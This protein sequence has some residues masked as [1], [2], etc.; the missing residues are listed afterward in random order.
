MNRTRFL[1]LL[2]LLLATVLLA[3]PARAWPVCTRLVLEVTQ[4]P[5]PTMKVCH[6]C[7]DDVVGGSAMPEPTSTVAPDKLT[8]VVRAIMF[9]MDGCPHCHEVLDNG[10]PSIQEKYG[11]KLEIKLIELVGG[12]EVTALYQLAE[13]RGISKEKVEVPFLVIGEYTLIGAEQIPA[14]LP[15]LIEEYLTSGGV[16]WPEISGLESADKDAT[17]SPTISQ[18]MGSP[19][20]NGRSSEGIVHAVLFNTPGCHDCELI[21]RQAIAPVREKFGDKF[22][23]QTIDIVSLED[24]DYLYQAA[25][26]Y[27]LQ[28]EQVDLPLLIIGDSVLVGEK[29]ISDLPELIEGYLSAGGV[30]YPQ[31]LEHTGMQTPEVKPS[32]TANPSPMQNVASTEP[33]GFAQSTTNTPNGFLPAI[34]VMLMMVVVLAYAVL[35]FMRTVLGHSLSNPPGVGRLEWLIPILAL[36]GIGVSGYL[37]YVETQAV[38]AVCG[39]VGDCNAVQSSPY[40]RLLG[41]L[42]VGV[43]GLIG[44]I[45]ILV[46]WYIQRSPLG[47]S[48]TW[49]GF[50]L[51]II[52]FGGTLFSLYL[53]YLE[54]FV[55]HA[56]CVWCLTS[57]VIITLILLLSLGPVTRHFKKWRTV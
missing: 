24:V 40:A 33:T 29:I 7:G 8:S 20:L 22:E 47:N 23:L 51:F 32:P 55:I 44:Y 45:L 42:P 38:P 39:P 2:L 12:E 1:A 11:E 50:V 37:A 6:I 26:V 25:A 3:S 48:A 28:T 13:S 4:C 14:E 18:L 16:D 15:G 21:F 56:V 52:A 54:P 53:T 5:T 27:G 35:V 43:L 34:L 36:L 46:A 57:A 31:L 30:D 19:T 10:L 49:A 41:L 9:W 17:P